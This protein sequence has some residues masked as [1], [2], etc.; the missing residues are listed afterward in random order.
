MNAS[1]FRKL[2]RAIKLFTSDHDD[3]SGGM[4]IIYKMAYGVDPDKI[5][6]EIITMSTDELL[7][8][9]PKPEKE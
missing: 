9:N 5:N 8:A 3:W 7:E 4:R 1:D 2:K 6:R